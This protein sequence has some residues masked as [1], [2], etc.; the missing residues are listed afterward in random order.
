MNVE[1]FR[2]K[3]KLNSILIIDG[4]EYRIEELVKF[5][6]DD[7]SYY[8]KCY[9]NDNYVFADDENENMFLLVEPIRNNIQEPFPVKLQ[10]KEKDFEFL[11]KAHAV[12]EEVFGND[13][14]FP[15]GDSEH[16]WDYQTED[17]SYLSLGINDQTRKRFD[18]YGKIIEPELF[19]IKENN[20]T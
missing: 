6:F 2:E 1:D 5:R 18:F 15:K 19:N 16:F 9:L 7:G 3:V 10:F 11:F 4:K 12:A 17:G 20:G 8:I 14:Y 13:S